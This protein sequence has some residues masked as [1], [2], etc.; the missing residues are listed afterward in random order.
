MFTRK[1]DGKICAARGFPQRSGRGDLITFDHLYSG[2]SRSQG[3][4]KES[5]AFVICDIY[6]GLIHAYPETSNTRGEMFAALR[7]DEKNSEGVL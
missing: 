3:L 2:A 1:D 6:T 5:E 4:E 7:W